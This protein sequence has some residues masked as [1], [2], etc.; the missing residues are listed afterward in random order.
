MLLWRLRVRAYGFTRS[1]LIGEF[2]TGQQAFKAQSTGR[3]NN[4]ELKRS[5]MEINQD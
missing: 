2:K 1:L 4:R 3:E 5:V